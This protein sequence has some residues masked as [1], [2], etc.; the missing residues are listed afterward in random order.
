MIKRLWLWWKPI[1]RK[2]ANFQA[3]LLLTIFYAVVMFPFGMAVRLLFDPLHTKR[4]P[5]R[6]LRRS[7]EPQDLTWAKRQ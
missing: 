2:I 5:V 7:L 1:A 6:W 4:R 3:R